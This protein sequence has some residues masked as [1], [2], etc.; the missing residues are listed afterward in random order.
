MKRLQDINVYLLAKLGNTCLGY[1]K[2][3][4]T[5]SIKEKLSTGGSVSGDVCRKTIK[6]RFVVLETRLTRITR[7]RQNE[8]KEVLTSEKTKQRNYG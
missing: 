8:K 6:K 5:R 2:E 1:F 3:K 4:K 7:M